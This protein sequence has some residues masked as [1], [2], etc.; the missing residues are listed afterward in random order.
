MLKLQRVSIKLMAKEDCKLD[1]SYNYDLAKEI[2]RKLSLV[3]EEITK[4]YHDNGLKVNKT[5]KNYKFLNV[6]LRFK[7]AIMNKEG[8]HIKKGQYVELV[9]GG[10]KDIIDMFICSLEEN[11]NVNILNASFRYEGLE[12]EKLRLK[13]LCLY[14]VVNSCIETIQEEGKVKSLDILDKRY[15]KAIEK[16]LRN[17]YEIVYG[18]K[19]DGTLEFHIEDVLTAKNKSIN[20]KGYSVYG[21]CKFNIFILADIDMQKI[22]YCSG[23][24]TH[25]IFGGGFLKFIKGEEYNE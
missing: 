20:I 7:N 16:N 15:L 23:L 6:S 25:N 10:R 24:G 8:I 22:A 4:D 19:Y 17:K 5:N 2:Y 9:M 11:D 14:E 13:N 3:N 18:K 1:Y 21:F 12:I